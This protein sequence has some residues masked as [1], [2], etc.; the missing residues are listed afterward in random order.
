[1]FIV[2]ERK[3]QLLFSSDFMGPNTHTHVLAISYS[4]TF[5]DCF[6]LDFTGT[7]V[8]LK[9]HILKNLSCFL[10]DADEVIQYK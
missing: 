8:D 9:P 2:R 10:I 3:S 1:M 5:L 7:L 6:T 4:I